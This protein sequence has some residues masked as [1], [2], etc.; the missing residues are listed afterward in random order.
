MLIS[1]NGNNWEPG[2]KSQSFI[3]KFPR[4][5]IE[6]NSKPSMKHLFAFRFYFGDFRFTYQWELRLKRNFSIDAC[7]IGQAIFFLSPC[8][9]VA[10]VTVL[11]RE[12]K[13]FRSQTSD[14]V[15]FWIE[16]PGLTAIVKHG[17]HA[18]TWYDHGDSYSPWYDHGKIMPCSHVFPTR[19]VTC[20]LNW[21]FGRFKYLCKFSKF[22]QINLSP[23]KLVCCRW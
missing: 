20:V 17:D 23:E 12:T 16:S 2:D 18:M 19:D 8:K 15:I 7:K 4:Q 9:I 22:S 13:F 14:K 6:I 3:W 21:C 5:G 11:K 1:K 10:N